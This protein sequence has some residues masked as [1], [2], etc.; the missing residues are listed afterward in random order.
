MRRGTLFEHAVANLEVTGIWLRAILL[1]MNLNVCFLGSHGG[2]CTALRDVR[3][4]RKVSTIW[5]NLLKQQV[6]L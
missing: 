3:S 6:L 1:L 4:G 2:K 5:R